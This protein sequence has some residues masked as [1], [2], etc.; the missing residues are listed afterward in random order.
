[1][2]HPRTPELQLAALSICT[3]PG[4]PF[5]LCTEA[6]TSTALIQL[7]Q[8]WVLYTLSNFH[9]IIVYQ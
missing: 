1:M 7:L 2:V 4:Q 8:V 6:E 5:R 9:Y 3:W